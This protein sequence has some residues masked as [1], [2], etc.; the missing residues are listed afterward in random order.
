MTWKI[1][2]WRLGVSVFV[3]FGKKDV[4]I[5]WGKRCARDIY[6]TSILGVNIWL[7]EGM[8]LEFKLITEVPPLFYKMDGR[9]RK[10]WDR[11]T[12]HICLFFFCFFAKIHICIF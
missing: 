8:T 6:D 4:D 5:G 10:D 2:R 11:S 1:G 12:A 7:V 9:F 3:C